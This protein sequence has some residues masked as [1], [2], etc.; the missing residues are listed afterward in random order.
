M[1]FLASHISTASSMRQASLGDVTKELRE[2]LLGKCQYGEVKRLLESRADPNGR[3]KY[4]LGPKDPP[5]GEAKVVN[6]CKK[7]GMVGRQ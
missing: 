3:L 1:L 2:V 5:A 7:R 6:M 4:K